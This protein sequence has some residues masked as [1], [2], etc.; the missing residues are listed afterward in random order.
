MTSIER[1]NDKNRKNFFIKLIEDPAK[2]T[3]ATNTACMF[4]RLQTEQET[5]FKSC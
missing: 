5:L 3:A 4:R 2:T 1:T